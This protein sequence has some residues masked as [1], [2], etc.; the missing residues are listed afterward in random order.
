LQKLNDFNG[1]IYYY[2][3]ASKMCPNRFIPLFELVKIYDKINQLTK[4]LKLAKAILVK[5]IKIQP[6]AIESLKTDF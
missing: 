4:A 6:F 3:L 2:L 5:P 1:A